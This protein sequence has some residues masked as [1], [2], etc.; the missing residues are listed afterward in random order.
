MDKA[1]RK[2]WFNTML[3]QQ[4]SSKLVVVGIILVLLALVYYLEVHKRFKYL[5]SESKS[6]SDVQSNLEP[7]SSQ[8]L[9]IDEIVRKNPCAPMQSSTHGGQNNRCGYNDLFTIKLGIYI[10][11]ASQKLKMSEDHLFLA[12][13]YIQTVKFSVTNLFNV[14]YAGL[15]DGSS[16]PPEFKMVSSSES[17]IEKC[18][19][20]TMVGMRRIDNVQFV[21]EDII[22]R[23]IKGDFIETGV[24]KGGVGIFARAVLTAYKQFNRRVLLADSFQGLSQ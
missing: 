21:L 1:S 17:T 14:N 5:L 10:N 2:K 19:A 4:R 23:G 8:L 22:Q 15:I 18:Q 13:L 20:P 3:Q 24:W 11:S 6:E 9:K 7:W 12:R 16:W